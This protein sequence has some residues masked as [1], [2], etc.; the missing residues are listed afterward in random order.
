MVQNVGQFLRLAVARN[1]QHAIARRDHAQIAV[2]RLGRMNEIGRPAGGGQSG[3]DL[4]PDMGRFAHAG[5]DHAPARGLDRG[6][7]ARKRAAKRAIK[8]G[9]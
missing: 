7:S 1:R 4:A 8:R 6:A 2:A 9:G 3:G 5:D